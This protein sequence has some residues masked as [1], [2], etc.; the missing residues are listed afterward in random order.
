MRLAA[1]IL[2]VVTSVAAFSAHA[3]VI[4]A[5]SLTRD[6]NSN[7]IVDTMN[8]REWLGFDVTKG[9][10]Y[11]QTVAAI[12]VGGIFEGYSI[13]RNA[14]AQLFINAMAGGA[15]NCSA[16][17][18]ATCMYISP[19][20]EN[21]VG[22]SGRDTR[23]LLGATYDE[24]VA[25]F[26]SDN[27]FLSP[28]GAI[29]VYTD[30]VRRDYVQKDNEWGSFADADFSATNTYN[31]VPSYVGW[32]LYRDVIPEPSND[33]PEPGS[34]ALAGLGLV[35]AIGARRRKRSV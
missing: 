35:A 6:T 15:N 33:V 4:T 23:A 34:L 2:T 7:T 17:G 3:T 18:N 13:A 32:L 19:D 8:N 14:D 22:E 11:A 12:G 16:F 25:F 24:D 20:I 28:V 29:I 31:G 5:G 27:G 26:L 9:L 10:S 21:L 30:D 1:L